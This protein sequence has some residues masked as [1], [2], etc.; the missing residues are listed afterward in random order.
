MKKKKYATSDEQVIFDTSLTDI[1][2]TT[3][4][5]SINRQKRGN[6]KLKRPSSN[7]LDE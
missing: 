1:E 4:I 6:R 2:Y 5:K 3:R 7:N